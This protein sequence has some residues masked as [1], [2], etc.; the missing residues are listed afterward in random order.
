M[1]LANATSPTAAEQLHQVQAALAHADRP[2]PAWNWLRRSWEHRLF[3][4]LT[5]GGS[6]PITHEALDEAD[7]KDNRRHPGSLRKILVAAGVLPDRDEHLAQVELYLR[8]TVQDH[9]QFGSMLSPYVRWSVLPRLRRRAR[10]RPTT[11]FITEWAT[12][13]IRSALQ[14][15]DWAEK[16]GSSL[17]GL[18]QEDI[19]QWLTGGKSTRYNVRDFLVWAHRRG[20]A[21][22]CSSPTED[23]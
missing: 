21:R 17:D 9:P 19:D 11:T 18:T 15:L 16:R 2:G 1:I 7:L 3:T 20:Y 6:R 14:L 13:R 10:T 5:A 22:D 12:A 4:S 8:R 23:T